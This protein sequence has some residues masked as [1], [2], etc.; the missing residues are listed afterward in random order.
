[1]KGKDVLLVKRYLESFVQIEQA[2]DKEEGIEIVL[3]DWGSRSCATALLTEREVEELT[4][5]LI[6]ALLAAEEIRDRREGIY[7]K[8]KEYEEYIERK[9]RELKDARKELYSLV[10]RVIER[11]LS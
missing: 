9:R 8:S 5:G 1:M 10:D 2:K 11:Y 4:E 6:K 3:H 7:I